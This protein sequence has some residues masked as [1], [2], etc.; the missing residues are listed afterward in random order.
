MATIRGMQPNPYEAPKGEQSPLPNRR[1]Q[2]ETAAK[3]GVIA[4]LVSLFAGY[5]A[6][7][8][9]A[10][11]VFAAERAALGEA[12]NSANSRH[13]ESGLLAALVTLGFAG[14]ISVAGIWAYVRRI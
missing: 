6:Y 3:L 1:L 5:L 4:I 10:G 8:I 2:W 12:L 11:A 9:A 7:E 13:F 14:V